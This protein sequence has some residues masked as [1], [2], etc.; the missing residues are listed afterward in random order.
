MY[1]KDVYI[2]KKYLVGGGAGGGGAAAAAVHG[3]IH[4]RRQPARKAMAKPKAKGKGK[5]KGKAKGKRTGN[6]GTSST[7]NKRVKTDMDMLLE[8]TRTIAMDYSSAFANA[9]TVLTCIKV[10]P[11]WTPA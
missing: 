4:K 8:T 9:K 11:E 1:C 10:M 6:N 7:S 2:S 3:Y 5:A